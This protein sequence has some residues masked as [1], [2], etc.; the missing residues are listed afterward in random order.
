MAQPQF[1]TMYASQKIICEIKPE[2]LED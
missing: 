2:M 1:K